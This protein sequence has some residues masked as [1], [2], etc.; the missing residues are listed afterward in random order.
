MPVVVD[1]IVGEG[2]ENFV[3]T[4][5]GELALS[6]SEW[7]DA[8]A[9]DAVMSKDQ[10]DQEMVCV[11]DGVEYAL[12][13]DFKAITQEEWDAAVRED[14]LYN[15]LAACIGDGWKLEGDLKPVL[16]GLAKLKEELLKGASEAIIMGGER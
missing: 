12:E 1:E 8:K 15:E 6:E 9:T 11:A 14:V 16:R 7:A 4:I 3:G 10:L 2:V 5:L 13:G